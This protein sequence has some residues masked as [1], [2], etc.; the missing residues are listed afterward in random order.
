MPTNQ[1]PTWEDTTPTWDETE[2]APAV[3]PAMQAAPAAAPS[4]DDTVPTW[5]DTADAGEASA[6]PVIGRPFEGTVAVSDA[7]LQ[8]IAARHGVSAEDLK[9]IA[10]YYGVVNP[11]AEGN[12]G[13]G[14]IAKEGVGFIGRGVLAGLPQGA[15]K[16]LQA[17]EGMRRALDEIQAIQDKH[18]EGFNVPLLGKMDAAELALGVASGSAVAKGGMKLLGAAAPKVATQVATKKG[19]LA[20]SAALGAGIAGLN[21]PEGEGLTYAAGG[22]VL[23][24]GAH[25]LGS[26]LSAR[27]GSKASRVAADVEEEVAAAVEKQSGKLAAEADHLVAIATR[28]KT[29]RETAEAVG[30]ETGEAAEAALQRSLENRRLNN[31]TQ[32]FAQYLESGGIREAVES[33]PMKDAVALLESKYKELGTEG[34]QREMKNFQL[35]QVAADTLADKLMSQ[36]PREAS[37][38][39]TAKTI[40]L[41]GR[42]VA[43]QID[44]RIGTSIE[45]VMDRVSKAGNIATND[46]AREYAEAL[47]VF[48]ALAKEFPKM[49]VKTLRA[50]E[51]KGVDALVQE[52]RLLPAQAEVLKAFETYLT[53]G[54]D[55]LVQKLTKAGLPMKEIANSKAKFYVPRAQVDAT[56][57]PTRIAQAA[58][59]IGIDAEVGVTPKQLEALAAK[60]ESAQGLKLLKDGVA[61]LTGRSHDEL[62]NPHLLS[63]GLKE[64]M[65]PGAIDAAARKRVGAQ[66]ARGEEG[67]PS[68]L[69]ETNLNKLLAKYVATNFKAARLNPAL[70]ELVKQRN[71]AIAAKDMDAA[72]YLTKVVKDIQGGRANT[73]GGGTAVATKRMVA[74]AKRLA[75]QSPEG[76]TNRAFY[77]VM[78]STPEMANFMAQQIYPNF[79]GL[80][81]KS[82]I[83]NLTQSLMGTAPELGTGY[84]GALV[85][86]NMMKVLARSDKLA[87]GAVEKELMAK[88]QMAHAWTQDMVE[89]MEGGIQRTAFEKIPRAA[90]TKLTK[91]SMK[92]FEL[93]EQMNRKVA[94]GT[95]TDMARDLFTPG[96]AEKALATLGNFGPAYRRE[97]QQ[98]LKKGDE[99]AVRGLIEDYIVGKS[100][101]HYNK[102]TMSEFGRSMGPIFSVFSKWPSAVAGDIVSIMAERGAFEGSLR[103]AQK[104]V[105]P[106]VLA[107]YL[108]R[109]IGTEDSPEIQA[110]I[111]KNGFKGMTPIGS[112][113]PIAEGKGF[114]PPAVQLASK[115]LKAVLEM[116]G[117]EAWRFFN[118]A[119]SAYMPGAI[120]LR[121]AGHDIPKWQGEPEKGTLL[122]KVGKQFGYDID[123]ALKGE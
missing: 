55:S 95:A 61:W 37:A 45:R 101:F 4:W 85:V 97:I 50:L 7:E 89:A 34:F 99:G 71:F 36:L 51:T 65:T 29:I 98:A 104:F 87:T 14:Q 80:N 68:F 31:A 33:K 86:K 72:N 2:A 8:D 111:G 44:L 119:T 26:V 1:A 66:L 64:A 107:A 112:L 106:T 54:S 69:R 59:S 9:G 13:I 63:L 96:R 28:Q 21:A 108:D 12:V 6:S 38:L 94:V 77:E 110:F 117:Y 113:M 116:D 74:Q 3:A 93:S 47:P 114:Q 41:D 78:A 105:A 88:G 15:F 42:E 115:G 123:A 39:N 48:K 82:V 100:L 70:S 75:A 43:R 49:D 20:T 19:A 79:L 118:E 76:S 84:G 11:D 92:V 25:K 32:E 67:V 122:G 121:L 46:V 103:V 22:A 52:G 90:L 62:N 24:A 57:A 83:Q 16:K 18:K 73:F 35:A 23:G 30:E 91:F 58:R 40:F 60:P 10:P 102:A 81:P 17:N 120:L 53:K 109:I 56:E 5:D 27:L